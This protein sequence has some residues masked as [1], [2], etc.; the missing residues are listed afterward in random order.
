MNAFA[1]FN[2][3]NNYHEGIIPNLESSRYDHNGMEL[4]KV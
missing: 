2:G 4:W 3:I 1:F